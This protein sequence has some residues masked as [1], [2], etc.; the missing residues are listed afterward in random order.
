MLR[1][2][3][4][5]IRIE[6]FE[7]APRNENAITSDPGSVPGRLVRKF[8]GVVISCPWSMVQDESFL[9]QF[10]QSV[11]DLHEETVHAFQ[12]SMATTSTADPRNSAHPGMITE[13]LASM[14]AASGELLPGGQITKHSREE[15]YI[16]SAR[17]P[18]RRTPLWIV[19]RV[20]IE[21]CLTY[22]LSIGDSRVH[23]KNFVLFFLTD[24]A[25]KSMAHDISYELKYLLPSNS[26]EDWPS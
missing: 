17:F 16:S 18:W 21:R 2:D 25:K 10:C 26:Q 8:P 19:L 1:N 5:N 13:M 20:A 7:A 4:D 23:F 3:A 12:N 22:Q 6:M 11:K 24:I 9:A 15:V 14:L